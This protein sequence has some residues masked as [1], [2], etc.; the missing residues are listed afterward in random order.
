MKDG[1][2]PVGPTAKT[3]P[4]MKLFDLDVPLPSHHVAMHNVL[5]AMA[6]TI[7]YGLGGWLLGAPLD[8]ESAIALFVGFL[9]IMLADPFLARKDARC[10]RYALAASGAGIL[11]ASAALMERLTTS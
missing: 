8:R 5:T 11:L 4:T 2:M 6:V 9:Y 10:K 3:D 7:G 1:R